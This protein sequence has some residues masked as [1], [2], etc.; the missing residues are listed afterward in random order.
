[1]TDRAVIARTSPESVIADARQ[2]EI[3]GIICASCKIKPAT[4]YMF[5]YG[6]SAEELPRPC[7]ATPLRRPA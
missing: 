4:S 7:L 1:M 5:A 3:T 6:S 2:A